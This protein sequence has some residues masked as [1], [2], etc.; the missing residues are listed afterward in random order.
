MDERKEAKKKEKEKQLLP[1]LLFVLYSASGLGA[2]GSTII[3][4]GGGRWQPDSPYTC[5]SLL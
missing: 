5:F 4:L 2:L 1:S 3:T